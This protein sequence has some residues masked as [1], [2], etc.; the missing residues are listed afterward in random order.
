MIRATLTPRGPLRIAVMDKKAAERFTAGE[1][2]AMISICNPD[3]EA[4]TL[5]Y[6]PNRRALLCVDAWDVN[7]GR[8]GAFSAAQARQMYSFVC[9]N[10]AVGLLVI[11]CYTGNSRSRGAALGISLAFG[12]DHAE[13]VRDGWP[14]PL[15]VSRLLSEHE[16][17]TGVAIPMPVVM[18]D[19]VRCVTH[20]GG[21]NAPFRDSEGGVWG[22]CSGCD[23]DIR[24]EHLDVFGL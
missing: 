18:R 20:P 23:A 8:D 22:R 16:R 11:H 4:R 24:G 10:R 5:Q 17:R 6:D 21:Y 14:N 2:Y 13:H 7:D 9:Q 19:L 3:G 12:G 15:F 1:P